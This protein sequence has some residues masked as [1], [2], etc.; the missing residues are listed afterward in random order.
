M[1]KQCMTLRNLSCVPIVQAHFTGKM[2]LQAIHVNKMHTGENLFKCELFDK[3]FV[4]KNLLETHTMTVHRKEKPH[5][6]DQ[7]GKSITQASSLTE[8]LRLHSGEK[9]FACEICSKRF[10]HRSKLKSHMVQHSGQKDVKNVLCHL[11]PDKF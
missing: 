3:K 8:H 11:C 2:A 7:C 9:P 10:T 1:L 6:C 5:V 4:M